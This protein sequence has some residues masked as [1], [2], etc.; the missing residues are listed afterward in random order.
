MSTA[1]DSDEGGEPITRLLYV[2]GLGRSGT[3]LLERILGQLPSACDVGEVVHLAERGIANDERCGCGFPFSECEFWQQVGKAAYGGWPNFD[4]TAVLALR[5]RVDRNRFIPRLAGT[6]RSSAP[7]GALAAY[8]DHYSRIYRACA[9]VSGA[10]VVIDAS[11]HPSL[12]FCLGRAPLVDLRVVHIVR[13][14]RGVAYSW[15][16]SVIRPERPD[17]TS[18]MPQYSVVYSALQWNAHN[19]AFH[20]LDR[21]G[22][23]VLRVFYEDLLADPRST[24]ERI[25]EF[26]GLELTDQDLD[27][28]SSTSA[29]L[30]PTHTVAGNPMRF[31]AERINLRRDDAW[32]HQLPWRRRL[33]VEVITLPLLAAYGYLSRGRGT[34]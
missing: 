27:F 11:K 26:A 3:T 31:G 9:E 23:P 33:A 4:P 2:G 21:C 13:D 19:L 30:S 12:A 34:R 18:Y 24:V 20:L 14:S 28:L 8:V 17:V 32:R 15:T 5:S 16:K 7:T 22:V 29:D 1:A 25:A 6:R 10:A